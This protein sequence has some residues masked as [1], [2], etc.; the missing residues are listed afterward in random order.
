LG[1]RGQSLK[2]GVKV[3]PEFLNDLREAVGK[4]R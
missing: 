1:G 4:E 2:P 3:N